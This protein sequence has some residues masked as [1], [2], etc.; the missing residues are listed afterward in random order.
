[1]RPSTRERWRGM[2]SPSTVIRPALAASRPRIMAIVRGLAGAVGAE[3][4]RGRARRHL[5]AEV[6][7]RHHLAVALG[8]IFHP[9]RWAHLL[10]LTFRAGMPAAL[11]ASGDQIARPAGAGQRARPGVVLDQHAW[12][13]LARKLMLTS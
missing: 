7:D 12:H 9:N 13:I 8:Q 5:E 1:M 11:A 2:S 6:V 3:Q 10:Q 4:R